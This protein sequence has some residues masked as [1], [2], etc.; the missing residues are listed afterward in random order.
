LRI[1]NTVTTVSSSLLFLPSKRL[2]PVCNL[3]NLALIVSSLILGSAT[4]L[5]AAPVN[6]QTADCPFGPLEP[7]T[8]RT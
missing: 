7:P 1:R 5:V 8:Q 2:T 3:R 4:G 6:C